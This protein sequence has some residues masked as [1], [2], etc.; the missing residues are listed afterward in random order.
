MYSLKLKITFL[1]VFVLVSAALAVPGPSFAGA[2]TDRVKTAAD[3]VIQVLKDPAL[4]GKAKDKERRAKIR[5]AVNNVFNF[6]EMAKRSLA[7][8]WKGRSDKEKKE[9]VDLFS[10]LLER[11]YINRIES[12]S[13]EKIVYDGEKLD[14]GY[15]VVNSRFLTRS[16]EE[17]PVDYKL[18][19]KDGQ[20]SVYDLVIENVSLV[21]NYRIQFNKIIRSSSYEDLVRKMKN[22]SESEALVSAPG[23]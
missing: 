12:Y 2:P 6:E 19:E 20:W 21:N 23:A 13:D 18:T 16:R 17:I 7:T 22:K 14:D 9:F 3:K 15:A 4:K 5:Q 1:A 8:Y 10:D 11:S